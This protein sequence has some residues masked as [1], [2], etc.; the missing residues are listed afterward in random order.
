MEKDISKCSGWTYAFG[1]VIDPITWGD[2]HQRW[3]TA[4]QFSYVPPEI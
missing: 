4:T 3:W 2:G 1:T